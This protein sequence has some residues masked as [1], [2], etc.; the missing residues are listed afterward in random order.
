MINKRP[1]MLWATLLMV[2]KIATSVLPSGK[3]M[4]QAKLNKFKS[5]LAEVQKQLS[6]ASTVLR[7][8]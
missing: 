6:V 7:D 1:S 8:C 3:K 2:A 4:L 5:A